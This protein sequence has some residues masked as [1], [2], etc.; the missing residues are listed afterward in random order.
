MSCEY[1]RISKVRPRANIA[2]LGERGDRGRQKLHHLSRTAKKKPRGGKLTRA[3]KKS[4]QELAKL[5]IIGEHIHR[6]LKI[7]RVLS[8]RYRNRRKRRSLRFNLIAGL[9]NY[10]L[11]LTKTKL[12]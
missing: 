8:S 9:Y 1:S 2:C 4:N 11:R 7:F 12:V 3:D 10:E 5:R 6:K